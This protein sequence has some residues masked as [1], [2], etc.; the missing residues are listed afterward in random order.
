MIDCT[1]SSVASLSKCYC[2]FSKK[3]AQ[4]ASV[5]LYCAWANSG[6]MISWTPDTEQADW[7]DGGGPHTG[8]LATFLATADINTVTTLGFPNGGLTGISCLSSLPALI[9]LDIDS[10][11]VTTID[12]T[13]CTSLQ[14]A[15]LGNNLLTSVDASPCTSLIQLS[16][17][18]NAGL[19]TLVLPGTQLQI[20]NCSGTQI[21]TLDLTGYNNLTALTSIGCPNLTT[22]TLTNCTS[23]TTVNCNTCASLTTL[24][25]TGCTALVTLDCNT[26]ALTTLD[27]SVVGATLVSVNCAFNSIN[28]PAGGLVLTGCSGLTTLNCSQNALS[29]LDCTN[30]IS[31][32]GIPSFDASFNTGP[33][34]SIDFTNCQSLVSLDFRAISGYGSLTSIVLTGASSMA[35]LL[36]SANAI[37]NLVI[38]SST[39]YNDV[40]ADG[41]ALTLVS[42][43]GILF[44]LRANCLANLGTCDLTGGTNSP[45]TLSCVNPLSDCFA[46]NAAG[47]AAT[48]N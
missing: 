2:G 18:N 21:A 8:D 24:T 23:L 17:A 32:L 31:L 27:L 36:C 11:L 44:N 47:W 41:N 1:P 3:E 46:L 25:L 7:T 43:D 45:P 19:T 12:L 6:C 30:L 20:L 9:T 33:L 26:C 4:A 15:F 38:G 28:N 29:T 42:V 13:G 10:N 35:S 22:L 16:V 48:T 14:F 39:F 40:E 34:V 5:F 37:T